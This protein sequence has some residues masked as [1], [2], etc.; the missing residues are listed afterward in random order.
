MRDA[1]P[2]G[3]TYV[4]NSLHITAG[5]QAPANPTDALGDDAAEFNSGSGGV[6]F[7]LGAGGNATTGGTI[8][9]GETVT[10]TFDV[11]IDADPARS[12]DPQPGDR[13]LHRVHAW[14]VVQRHDATGGQH[15]GRPDPDARQD[16]CRQPDRRS[17]DDVH[18]VGGQCRQ[19]RR[20]TVR[21]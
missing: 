5:P 16:A 11:T 17:A 3:T 15:G 2:S 10:V 1:I 8:A 6:V 21:P 4:P 20:P 14:D 9:P 18:A 7:R 12:A 19:L 13:D